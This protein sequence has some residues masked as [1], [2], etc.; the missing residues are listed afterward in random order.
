MKE[1]LISLF[2][3]DGAVS[4][5]RMIAFLAMAIFIAQNIC[6]LCGIQVDQNLIYSTV[7]LVCVSLGMTMFGK[8]N[9]PT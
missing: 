4:S 6:N 8:S 7:G 5:K 2:R 1:F 3:V 9:V